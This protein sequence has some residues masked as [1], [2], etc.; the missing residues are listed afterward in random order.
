[1][2]LGLQIANLKLLEH[3]IKK[4]KESISQRQ[5]NDKK[6]KNNNGHIDNELGYAESLI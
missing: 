6:S 1:M 4:T 3:T 2:R 5:A